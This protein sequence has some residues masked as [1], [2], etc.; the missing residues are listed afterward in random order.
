VQTLGFRS[1]RNRDLI[2]FC[3]VA[4]I[5]YDSVH[6]CLTNTFTSDNSSNCCNGH[7]QRM[8][9][10]KN[11]AIVDIKLH[12]YSHVFLF[13][14]TCIYCSQWKKT[15]WILSIFV[16]RKLESIVAY[17]MSLTAQH[18]VYHPYR[19]LPKWQNRYYWN[20]KKF[21]L[22]LITITVNWNSATKWWSG[23]HLLGKLKTFLFCKSF[24]P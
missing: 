12:R 8:W 18:A 21:I 19:K 1:T 6:T 2:F 9:C 13:H 11:K 24:P 23:M 14:F 20:K 5:K 7:W 16:I 3:N 15:H 4:D 17:H 10:E 22:R